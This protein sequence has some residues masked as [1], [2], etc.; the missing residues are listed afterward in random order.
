MRLPKVLAAVGLIS[1]TGVCG[2]VFDR[3]QALASRT[4][5]DE[6]GLVNKSA[7]AAAMSARFPVGSA[8]A[9]LK[10][11]VAKSGGECRPREGALWCEFTYRVGICYAA[12]VGISVVE[13]DGA[14]QHMKVEVGGLGC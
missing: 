1:I 9:P 3:S 8:I 6:K 14:I 5:L 13:R 12:M 2:C 10:A 7:Y 11:Y 4:L